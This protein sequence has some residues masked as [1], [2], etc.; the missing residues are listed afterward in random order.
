MSTLA[1]NPHSLVDAIRDGRTTFASA[2]GPDA[3]FGFPAEATA[4][5]GR[6]IVATLGDILADAVVEA[7]EPTGVAS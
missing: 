6:A 7:I 3:Y 1:P 2:G 5:E 4:E